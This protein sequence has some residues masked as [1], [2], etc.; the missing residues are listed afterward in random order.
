MQPY[1]SQRTS[2]RFKSKF[3]RLLNRKRKEK[4]NLE[5]LVDDNYTLKFF[6][7]G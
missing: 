4:L 3:L 2:M 5:V 7:K 6:P 1:T